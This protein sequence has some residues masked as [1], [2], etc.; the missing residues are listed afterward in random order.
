MTG[1]R[2]PLRPA[3]DPADAER[4]QEIVDLDLLSPEADAVLQEIAAEAA[5]RLGMPI[6]TV[7]VVLDEAQFFA[8]RHG[9]EG[10]MAESLG[11]PVEWS[12]CAHAVASRNE[13][14]VEDATTH[15]TV[16]HMPIV[17]HDRVICY[18]GIP[19][20]SSRGHVLGTLCVIGHE[21]HAFTPDELGIL[22]SL[23]A[24]AVARIEARRRPSPPAAD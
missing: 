19:L 24:R 15:P 11:T 23:A 6:S 8:A 4:L 16:R 10:W 7:S 17:E 2:T 5:Q 14:V 13:F 22:R 18:A 20:V 21:P 9:V 12:F 3:G 1:H